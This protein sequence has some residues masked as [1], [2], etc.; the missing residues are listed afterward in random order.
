MTLLFM[1]VTELSSAGEDGPRGVRGSEYCN[2]NNTL[3]TTHFLTNSQC[4]MH[5]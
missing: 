5:S 4:Q 3:L 1:I 2:T